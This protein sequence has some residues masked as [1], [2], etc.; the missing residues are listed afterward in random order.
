MPI[1]LQTFFDSLD[2]KLYVNHRFEGLRA[3]NGVALA[4]TFEANCWRLFRYVSFDLQ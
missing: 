1:G 3:A 2:R 4:L